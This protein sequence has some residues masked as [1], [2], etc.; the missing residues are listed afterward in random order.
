MKN[1]GV[2]ILGI[3]AILSTTAG[4]SHAGVHYLSSAQCQEADSGGFTYGVDWIEMPSDSTAMCPGADHATNAPSITALNVYYDGAS[5][6]LA[7][8]WYGNDANGGYV[9]TATRYSCTTTGGCSSSGGSQPSGYAYIAW[10]ATT[11]GS[12]MVTG[13]A[14]AAAFWNLY[15]VSSGGTHHI[16]GYSQVF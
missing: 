11:G 2:C 12:T 16:Y 3:V 9:S 10:N 5:G 14:V 15:C 13:S 4:P 8:Q 7:C 1:V 6:S